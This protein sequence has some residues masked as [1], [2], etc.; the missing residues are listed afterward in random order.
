MTLRS[1]SHPLHLYH[2]SHIEL[3]E[4]SPKNTSHADSSVDKEASFTKTK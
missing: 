3:A 1:L 4:T 2:F